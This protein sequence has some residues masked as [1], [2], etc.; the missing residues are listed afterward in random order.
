MI[1]LK[2][3]DVVNSVFKMN[4]YFVNMNPVGMIFRYKDDN[5]YYH[6][7]INNSGPY[8]ILLVKNYEGKQT[9]LASS[10][11]SITPR[12]FY[13]FTVNVSFDS[14]SV[15]LKIGKLRNIQEIFNVNDND[16]QRG[17]LGLATN[18]NDEFYVTSIFI[19]N[20]IKSKKN[21]TEMND[22]RKFDFVL[23]ENT[24]NHRTKFCKSRF[25]NDLKE[26]TSCKEFHNFCKIQCDE[27]VHAR[28]NILNYFCFKSCV[29]DSL[30]KMKIKNMQMGDQVSLGLN[31]AIW[32]PKEKEKCDFRPDDPSFNSSWTQC[33]IEKVENNQNDPEQKIL[34]ISYMEKSLKKSASLLYPSAVLKKCGEMISSRSDCGK[35]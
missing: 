31:P 20:Y 34:R 27:N 8:K 3:A 19:D 23:K 1:L 22:K 26:A 12:V 7:R 25:D 32:S 24:E 6:L 21:T 28:E 16:L 29:R 15:T 5:N 30:L 4:I 10:N 35:F 11:I 18:G 2:N 33:K 14:I 17:S 13:S 9:I